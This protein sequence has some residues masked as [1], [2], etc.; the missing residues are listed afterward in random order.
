MGLQLQNIGDVI[1]TTLNEF[2]PDKATDL[3]STLQDF[4]AAKRLMKKSRSGTFGGP[5]V[6]WDL[7]IDH[8]NS[9]RFTELYSTDTAAVIDV[10][11]RGKVPWTHFEYS[12]HWDKRE[13][14]A[15]IEPNRLYSLLKT[16]RDSAKAASVEKWERTFW[17]S[18]SS[19][20]NTIPYSLSYWIVKSNTAATLANND[21]FNGGLP[22]GFSVVGNINPST[23]SKWKN[24]ATQYTDITPDDFVKK[25][26][27]ALKK[28]KF[29][30]VVEDMPTYNTG[31]DYGLYCN[32]DGTLASIEDILEDQNEN[33]GA[34][35]AW[36][37]GKAVF[38]G[39]PFVDVPFLE[40]DTTNPL[41]GINWGE[42][43]TMYQTGRM[44]VK[45]VVDPMPGQHNCV[46]T[47]EDTTMQWVTRN[48]RR[49]FVLA[50]D[51]TMPI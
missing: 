16:R 26:R 46:G 6:E 2:G 17:S 7:I 15:N 23:Y 27:R 40:N 13:I 43:K 35:V 38:K 51:T 9:A 37:D 44:N 21:G 33:L 41:Y 36:S 28:T 48:R 22:S 32:Y 10:H 1:R 25:L 49:H 50:T 20:D 42:F 3:I 31:D 11:L 39:I 19:S 47:Y 45:T 4:P 18:A 5:E 12:Y 14:A 24:Y 34:D 29:S 30:S 8:N